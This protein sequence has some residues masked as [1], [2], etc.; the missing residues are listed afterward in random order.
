MSLNGTS[1]YAG[2]DRTPGLV[3]Q[4]V[5]AAE[6]L[7]FESCVRPETGRLLAILAGGLPEGSLVGETGTGTGAGLG[8]MVSAAAPSVRFVGYEIDADRVAACRHV[9]Q[10]HA[11]VEVVH[12]DASELFGRGPFDL[13]VHDGGP[14]SGKRA[15][16]APIDPSGVL[17][18]GGLMTV[19]D[20]TPATTWPPTFEGGTDA[21]RVHWLR[22]HDLRCAEIR[23][24]P[25]LAVVVGTYLPR[26]RERSE[27]DAVE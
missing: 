17:S 22:H 25:D 6:S 5:R 12:G 7:G 13:L 8:W 1:S 19:D 14:G 3:R 23:V 20:F 11:N 18:P 16:D 24:A 27:A 4:A 9:F 26:G 10:H 2:L 15:G 21:A